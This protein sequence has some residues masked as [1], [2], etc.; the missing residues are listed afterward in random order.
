MYC[1][2]AFCFHPALDRQFCRNLHHSTYLAAACCK[3]TP[4][5]SAMPHPLHKCLPATPHDSRSLADC[6]GQDALVD[7]GPTKMFVLLEMR[8]SEVTP[9]GFLPLNNRT[10]NLKK[11]LQV[12][13][14]LPTCSL[15]GG[16]LHE[17]ASWSGFVPSLTEVSNCNL[18]LRSA[19]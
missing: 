14:C 9:A 3:A 8:A 16:P 13:Q 18:K 1:E 4:V 15:L 10:M 19:S 7:S 6:F 11:A 12:L 5:L 2:L 17:A